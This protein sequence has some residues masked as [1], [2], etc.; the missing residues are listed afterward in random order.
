MLADWRVASLGRENVTKGNGHQIRSMRL[1][2]IARRGRFAEGHKSVFRH[3]VDQV[4]IAG[5]F[6]LA[7]GALLL[8]ADCLLGPIALFGNFIRICAEKPRPSGRR[9]KGAPS[10]DGFSRGE[11]WDDP[12][13]QVEQQLQP[14]R[15]RLTIPIADRHTFFAPVRF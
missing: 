2:R 15:F 8:S 14:R 12:L 13:F 5:D 9:V 3:I 1:R 4:D 10:Q 7:F 6:Q 11:Y